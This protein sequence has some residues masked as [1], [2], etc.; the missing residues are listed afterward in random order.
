MEQW[1]QSS[2]HQENPLTP[3]ISKL[4]SFQRLLQV[5]RDGL[6]KERMLEVTPE[7]EEGASGAEIWGRAFQPEEV[8]S[9]QALWHK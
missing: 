2:Q 4:L 9:A 7:C 8:A 1:P 6:T 5:A 3:V